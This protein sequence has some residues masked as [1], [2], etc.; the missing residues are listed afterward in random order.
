VQ[1]S[2]IYYEPSNNT[3]VVDRSHSSLLDGFANS[4]VIGYFYPYTIQGDYGNA[5]QEALAWDIFVDG[6]LVEIYVN[7]RFA[8]TT[9]IYPSMESST[10]VG[11]YVPS[12]SSATFESIDM[13]ST[14]YNVFPERPLNSSSKLVW[15]TIEQTNNRTWWTGN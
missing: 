14:L 8:L 13:W 12:G 10:G 6:S 5:T 1:L 9:R 11:I 15:D 7:D 4:S 3:I 2:T